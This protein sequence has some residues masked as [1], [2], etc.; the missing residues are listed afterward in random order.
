[1]RRF[2]I[3][4]LI[5]GIC[6]AIA[7]SAAGELDLSGYTY[8]ELSAI[9][10][11]IDARMEEIKRE[12][13]I[14]NADR[15]IFFEQDEM[16][17]Y[18][19][20]SVSQRPS[21]ERLTEDAPWRTRFDWSSSDETIALVDAQGTVTAI[22]SGDAVITA[23]VR[24]N[25]YL[26]ASY[27]VHA[28]IPVERITVWGPEEPIA[29]GKEGESATAVL[30]CS[31]EP[32]EAYYQGV[33]WSSSD[34]ETATVDEDGTVHGV[35]PGK[36][37]IT[38]TSIEDPTTRRMPKYATYEITIIQKVTGIIPEA[39]E[40]SLF[41]GETFH[42]TATA[43]P[44]N[45]SNSRLT[46]ESNNPEIAA[47]D[48]TGMITARVPGECNI[49]LEAADGY[50]AA[51][52]C[53]VTVSKQ[54]QTIALSEDYLRL[55]IGKTFTIETSVSPEDATNKELVWTS[56]N[57]FVA[58]V[59]NGTVEAVG[60]GD[61]EITCSSTDGSEISISIPVRVPTFS[62]QQEEYVITD[63][64]GIEI[65]IQKAIR[66]MTV[67]ARGE[68]ECFTAKWKAGKLMIKPVAAG[69]GT[70]TLYNPKAKEDDIEIRIRVEDSAVY[71]QVSYP[72]VSY[73]ELTRQPEVYEGEQISLYGKVL[74]KK[75]DGEGNI[76]LMVGTGGKDY[77]DQV[78]QIRLSGTE[79]KAKAPDKGVTATF[80]GLF[81][82]EKVFS[83]ALGSEI[84]VPG[85]EAE[86][87]EN[88]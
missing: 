22:G 14:A 72:V 12:E 84:S 76:I 15:R 3:G 85:M 44:E 77:T 75:D 64:S 24:D 56:S 87:I 71:N 21:V 9:R 62:V 26:E 6:L 73:E 80:Y 28:V 39:E 78:L 4:I 42:I 70:V 25:P 88:D 43:E 48:E 61:C 67:Q 35:K 5:A 29:L 27:T 11:E 30:G 16:I 60:Q 47:V 40:I 83:E 79:M 38:A 58:R 45:A 23:T 33:I 32:E 52:T 51:A 2:I 69:E 17:V 63:K 31:A 7:V 50:G 10:D 86:R 57:V 82:N 46:Y 66:G 55:P 19:D 1:M 20:S 8:D 49:I 74:E 68:S 41:T 34:E 37:V 36:V 65:T 54:V 53:H 59:A 18:P 13:A 81:R